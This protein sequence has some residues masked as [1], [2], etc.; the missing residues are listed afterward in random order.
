MLIDVGDP[1]RNLILNFSFA[2][3]VLIAL[4]ALVPWRIFGA[5]RLGRM[6]IWLPVPTLVVAIAYEAAMPSRF[7]IRLDL[8]LLAPAYA[9]VLL[10]TLARLIAV[11]RDR[12][13]RGRRRAA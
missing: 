11:W 5:R 8:F 10:A 7:D 1:L 3:V 9:L 2:L 13:K 6:A 4:L 12:R